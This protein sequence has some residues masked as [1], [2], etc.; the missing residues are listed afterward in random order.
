MLQGTDIRAEATQPLYGHYLPLEC[1]ETQFFFSTAFSQVII[2]QLGKEPLKHYHFIN[3]V[4]HIPSPARSVLQLS[5]VQLCRHREPLKLL[6]WPE[7]TPWT[8]QHQNF[9][10][11]LSQH[12]EGAAR[13]KPRLVCTFSL[14]EGKFLLFKGTELIVPTL[15]E[16]MT[17]AA[18]HLWVRKQKVFMSSRPF[19]REEVE[20]SNSYL[21]SRGES[22]DLT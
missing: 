14:E 9:Q 2:R 5:W 16:N 19:R 8:E 6:K 11:P 13:S 1:L 21:E 22:S 3:V 7:I 17:H 20:I 10:S 15:K 4:F 18:A 12:Q